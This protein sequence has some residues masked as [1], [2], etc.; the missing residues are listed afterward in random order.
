MEVLYFFQKILRVGGKHAMNV[1]QQLATTAK[2]CEPKM[3]YLFQTSSAQHSENNKKKSVHKRQHE[4]S[5][6][7]APDSDS[8]ADG[9]LQ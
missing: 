4:F 2:K 8:N 3:R 9:K 5:K 6:A 7:I 1:W